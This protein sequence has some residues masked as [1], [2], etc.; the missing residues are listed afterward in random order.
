MQDNYVIS[1]ILGSTKYFLLFVL[2]IGVFFGSGI[3]IS[4]FIASRAEDRTTIIPTDPNLS[5]TT[6]TSLG[7]SAEQTL[8]VNSQ[9]QV[10]GL[11]SLTPTAAPSQA[12]AGT[13]YFDQD[14]QTLQYY[15]GTNFVPV[16]S[17]DSIPLAT[18]QSVQG[19]TGAIAFSA[20]QGIGING[21]VISSSGLLGV[22]GVGG[23]INV[24][25]ANGI[26]SLSIPQD[27]STSAAP[28]FSGLNL[29]APLP[30]SSGGTGTNL[31]ALANGVVLANGTNAF[32]S[33]TPSA[34][35]Q[36]LVSSTGG[37]I[38]FGSCTG[39][40]GI[41]SLN[42][43][44]GTLNISG[45]ANRVLVTDDGVNTITLNLPQDIATSST[46][47]FSGLT[48][49]TITSTGT[50]LLIGPSD[51]AGT[52]IR[53]GNRTLN[54][55][56]PTPPDA[57]K[58]YIYYNDVTNKLRCYENGGWNDCVAGAPSVVTLQTA[59]NLSS[60][61][62]L[63][64]DS[65]RG[66]LTIRD[67]AT[68]IGTNLLEVQNNG[69]STTYLAV[70][71]AGTSLQGTLDSNLPD[72]IAAAFRLRESTNDY[73]S[74]TTTNS[75][76]ALVLGNATTNPD[77][78]FLGN[79]QFRIASLDC[80]SFGNGGALT[81]DATGV[82]SCSND[83]TGGGGPA[84]ATVALDNLSGVAINTSLLPANPN[85]TNTVDL[86]STTRP[87]R[88]L[89]IQNAGLAGNYFRF[90]GTATAA[91]T[92]TIPD[93]TGEICLSSGNCVGGGGG[94]A[95]SGAS[96]LTLSLDGSLSAE[97]V[98]TA[99]TNISIADGG[100]NSTL[101]VNVVNNPTFSGLVTASAGLTVATGQ[102]LTVNGV[103]L[104]NLVGT[105]L[106]SSGGILQTTL[107]ASVDLTS[108]VINEL[109][110]VN[111]GTGATDASTA[112]TNLGAAASGANS[113]ITSLSVATLINPAAALTIGTATQNLTL[114][115]SDLAT[116]RGTSGSFTTTL[117]FT[118]PTAN[119]SIL[120]PALAAGTYTLCTTSGN[121]AGVGGVGDI[122][123]NGQNGPITIGTNNATALNFETN[124][125]VV[126]RITSAGVLQ[127]DG[128]ATVSISTPSTGVG[129][130]LQISSGSGTSSGGALSLYSGNATSTG[131]AGQ[132]DIQAGYS[133][134][135]GGGPINIMGG[136]AYNSANTGGAVTVESG[137]GFG[138]GGA[139]TLR[140]GTGYNN[141]GGSAF[142]YGGLSEFGTTGSAYVDAGGCYDTCAYGGVYIGAGIASSVT[143]GNTSTVNTLSLRSVS[144]LTLQSASG[145]IVLGATDS[146][147][148]QLVLDTKN[149]AGDPTGVNG[150]IYYNSN[151]N[152]GEF[153]CFRAGTW[154]NCS[155]GSFTLQGAYD[156]GNTILTTNA[157]DIAFTLADTATD[158][159]FLVN[160]A[161]G[162]TSKFAVQN[163]GTDVLR[164]SSSTTSI[165]TQTTT[166]DANATGSVV[167]I[168]TNN[169]QTT[170]IGRTDAVVNR[171]LTLRSNL[172]SFDLLGTGN[173]GLIQFGSSCCGGAD[174]NIGRNTGT[175]VIN[176]GA[177]VGN[178]SIRTIGVG[179]SAVAGSTTAL[180]I[181]SLVG[182]S[183]TIIQGG[184]SNIAL[185]T[186]GN[187][188]I[189][190]SDT[191]GT[192]LVLDTKTSAGDPAGVNGGS[193]YN[194]NAG[195]FRCFENS[196]WKDCIPSSPATNWTSRS[197]SENNAWEDVEYGNGMFVAVS[198]NGTNRVMTSPDGVN[199]TSRSTPITEA[200]SNI[201][202]GNGI[203]I[204]SSDVS[205]NI[206]TS[207]DG[208]NW[209]SVTG[210]MSNWSDQIAYGNNRFVSVRSWGAA[211][212]AT[213]S[214]DGVVWSNGGVLPT[215][216]VSISY[217]NGVFVTTDT[218]GAADNIAT[219]TDGMSWTT[220]TTD[221]SSSMNTSTYGNG[222]FVVFGVIMVTSPDGITWT[223]RS[224]GILPV[225]ATYGDGVYVGV[226]T[227]TIS[228]ST[229]GIT[230]N[231]FS[232]PE[233][234]SWKSVAYGNGVFVAVSSDGTNR[235]MTSGAPMTIPFSA[236]NIYQGGI[237]V[238]GS[239]IFRSAPNS[240]NMFQVQNNA[241]TSVLTVNTSTAGITVGG[242]ITYTA[243]T[244]DTATNVCRNS[245]GQLAGCTSAQRFKDN[246]ADLTLGLDELRLLQPV[247]YTWNTNGRDDVGF[248]AEQVA[249]VIP[250]AVT[251]DENGEVAS[252]NYNTIS[253]LLVAGVQQLDLKVTALES[254]VANLEAG[255]FTGNV[256][257]TGD[258]RVSGLTE[259][260][261]LK[262]NGR[263]V[264][265]GDTPNAVLGTSAGVGASYTIEG[266]DTAGTITVI[267]GVSPLN[268]EQVELQFVRGLTKT[269]RVNITPVG[270][271]AGN[272][273]HY[274]TR[275]T[276][277][278]TLHFIEPPLPNTTYRFDYL[279]V[280]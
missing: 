101:T 162:S 89:Y 78:T 232:S 220:R 279:V 177:A 136:G 32:T 3:G 105:G 151:I 85:N 260:A 242:T 100:A 176:I 258:L 134:D 23:T 33:V 19:Q 218:S 67:N 11:L 80:T 227:S 269:P 275:D 88:D 238:N 39:T 113:D 35:G 110:I 128:L 243:G 73:L 259:V 64:L 190:T 246:V 241:G 152:G 26:A 203:F 207:K 9:L 118:T 189:G 215:N 116:L 17:Q 36:C 257:I 112:R 8:T 182:T 18:V 1:R 114:Q 103:A 41:D 219:S 217:G 144:N 239:S 77:F 84:G 154:G 251:Y 237:T 50:E 183:S 45:T 65:T 10:N 27:I 153:R 31:F 87:F 59:Y 167:N 205:T 224:P 86:G 44:V 170:T 254:R 145:N 159:N 14:T 99:G 180:T 168:S 56:D 199:W 138:Y 244:A 272:Q 198:S 193:Y 6:T 52:L 200:W 181:G 74:V 247:S 186:T 264:T 276:T 274:I 197:A 48:V 2:I 278:F 164:V 29:S 253:A 83:D 37:I 214:T 245:S 66:G 280:Q 201:T 125:T 235:V 273:G 221:P 163:N 58:G 91:R 130:N 204:A 240:T 194:S 20:G 15:N 236:D 106:S 60:N 157:R 270:I 222:L 277:G 38:Q 92:I 124:N 184:S 178:G 165:L 22:N 81:A 61:P 126:W 13:L 249:Q 174:I 115:G 172:I 210:V 150:G 117:G 47:Q 90:T 107:G 82:I 51:T 53:L 256:T 147:G 149:T 69:G 208:I 263:I 234:N 155:G 160:I 271:E 34:V 94:S 71:A 169:V 79:G 57:A 127:Y 171:L 141:S 122:L 132:I 96:Y 43:L 212:N 109:P 46:P 195:K 185:R 4:I 233:G 179:N 255:V 225:A 202:Y 226:S 42:S 40:S 108:E 142:L 209:T 120:L 213:V 129:R 21:T 25:T 135:S 104:T 267:T 166:I 5:T 131:G 261:N 133:S 229:N 111:G 123:N 206:I 266:N 28:S 139:I 63:T 97:R 146:I 16:A 76:E 55:A 230:W 231:S 175:S 49:G 68:P 196:V 216:T 158:S 188:T 228:T 148:T 12:K 24:T 156:A 62:E 70:T 137:L 211:T 191:T 250:Q 121:C 248:I 187:V 95:P 252:F 93:A 30:V 140:G 75:T 161:S 262:V 54:S 223:T 192:Q 72:N 7:P 143:V 268:G 98:L 173:D 102:N 119:A 265:G